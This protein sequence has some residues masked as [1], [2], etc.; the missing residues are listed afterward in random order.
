MIL[1]LREIHQNSMYFGI[2]IQECCG[3]F[4]S[5]S[6]KTLFVKQK[7]ESEEIEMPNWC[8]GDL[9]VRGKRIYC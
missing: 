8:T 4:I 2:S 9:K 1:W 3:V 5:N 7:N 6:M